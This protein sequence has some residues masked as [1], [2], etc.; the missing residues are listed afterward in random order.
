MN[1]H[2]S[3][4]G[5]MALNLAQISN[6]LVPGACITVGFIFN[7][8]VH[9]NYAVASIVKQEP[10]LPLF[11][12]S[13]NSYDFNKPQEL[14]EQVYLYCVENN[15]LKNPANIKTKIYVEKE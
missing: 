12:S 2:N 6:E 1:M 5:I 3:D 14:C 8:N 7:D 15:L 11:L 9:G 10:E 13:Y 4:F